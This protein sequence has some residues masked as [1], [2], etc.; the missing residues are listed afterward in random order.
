MFLLSLCYEGVKRVMQE[1]LERKIGEDG[2]PIPVHWNVILD[3]SQ[4]PI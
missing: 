3:L 2:L 1:A 4:V